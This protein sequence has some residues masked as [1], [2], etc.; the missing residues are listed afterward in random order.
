MMGWLQ[1]QHW[2][3]GDQLPLALLLLC[4]VKTVASGWTF[5]G[6]FH[7][8]RAALGLFC[9][10]MSRKMT[11]H[12]AVY[13]NITSPAPPTRPKLTTCLMVTHKL[14]KVHCKHMNA[15]AQTWKL[16]EYCKL[17]KSMALPPIPWKVEKV[18]NMG[19]KTVPLT[20]LSLDHPVCAP[21]TH[22]LRTTDWGQGEASGHQGRIRYD[23]LELS[24]QV[25]PFVFLGL[26]LCFV[27]RLYPMVLLDST[28]LLCTGFPSSSPNLLQG[29]S[30]HPHQPSTS[31]P[32]ETY[33]WTQQ[34]L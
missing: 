24:F 22:R 5:P 29:L 21:G 13:V 11:L 15:Q 20:D 33:L 7:F 30:L 16:T 2:N 1:S 32:K 34:P 3:G 19:D 10:Q 9:L 8:S 18:I 23:P 28:A 12:R 17:R 6:R 31:A 27:W 4:Y 25:H 26:V 14:T